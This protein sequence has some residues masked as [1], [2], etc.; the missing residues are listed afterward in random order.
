M[1]VTE[2][3]AVQDSEIRRGIACSNLC[4]EKIVCQKVRFHRI[5][6]TISRLAFTNA[7]E[8]LKSDIVGGLKIGIVEAFVCIHSAI[9][10]LAV[11]RV[12]HKFH[13]TSRS[14]SQAACETQ[15]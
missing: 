15:N 1:N 7:L 14:T 2:N 6:L 13:L 10:N 5:L 8:P 4:V 11:S 3:M 12:V 9:R